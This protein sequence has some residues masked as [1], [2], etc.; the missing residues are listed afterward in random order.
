MNIDFTA[1]ERYL[2]LFALPVFLMLIGLL[3]L[4]LFSNAAPAEGLAAALLANVG[5][6]LLPA[7]AAL[8]IAACLWGAWNYWLLFR[9]ERGD[10]QGGC[11]RCGGVM[12]HKDGRYGTYSV[13]KMCGSKREGWH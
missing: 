5:R 4:M 6:I 7:S 2:R 1:I 8:T 10:L 12:S 11:I 9:W 13:C 3:G